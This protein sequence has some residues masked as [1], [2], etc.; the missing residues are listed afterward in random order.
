MPWVWTSQE[1][2]HEVRKWSARQAES[3]VDRAL[4]TRG[5]HLSYWDGDLHSR[6]IPKAGRD[7]ATSPLPSLT[8]M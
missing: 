8:H 6:G 3:R 4:L 2:G 1:D 5:H 7:M